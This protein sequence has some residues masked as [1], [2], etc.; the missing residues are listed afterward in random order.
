MRSR[1]IVIDVCGD[2]IEIVTDAET[3]KSKIFYRIE[4]AQ[5]EAI[6]CEKG[7]VVNIDK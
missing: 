7:I 1:Y 5:L 2:D 6:A 3:G 4:D